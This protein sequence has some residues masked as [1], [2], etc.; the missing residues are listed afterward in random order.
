MTTYGEIRAAI[1]DA[2]EDAVEAHPER[3]A[4]GQA[5]E[6]KTLTELSLV[7]LASLLQEL[8]KQ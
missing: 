2:I 4:D 7:Q 5:T 3:A 6:H 1:V 8:V